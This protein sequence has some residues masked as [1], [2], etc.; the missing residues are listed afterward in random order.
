M[1]R[2]IV[3]FKNRIVNVDVFCDEPHHGKEFVEE[4][5]IV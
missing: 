5:N 2:D 4:A 3:I 1:L